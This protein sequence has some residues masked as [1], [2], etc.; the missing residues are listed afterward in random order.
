MRVAWKT[1]AGLKLF[2]LAW[3]ISLP[4]GGTLGPFF[5]ERLL[6]KVCNAILFVWRKKAVTLV[7]NKIPLPSA[8]GGVWWAGYLLNLLEFLFSCLEQEKSSM[9][10]LNLLDIQKEKEF[11][12]HENS[13]DIMQVPSKSV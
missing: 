6:Y 9:S 10:S 11:S 1:V 3:Q 12:N 8:S 13:D 7:L 2:S 5:A 4:P